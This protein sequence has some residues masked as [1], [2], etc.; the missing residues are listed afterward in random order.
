MGDLQADHFKL[1]AV[2]VSFREHRTSS[3]STALTASA[4]A[5]PYSM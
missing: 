4:A 1:T 5:A 3:T 2:R